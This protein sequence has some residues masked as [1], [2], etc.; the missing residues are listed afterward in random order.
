MDTTSH[1]VLLHIM[2]SQTVGCEEAAKWVRF[3]A[4]LDVAQIGVAGAL[5]DIAYFALSVLLR[6]FLP[7]RYSWTRLDLPLVVRALAGIFL[8]KLYLG[9]PPPLVANIR[10]CVCARPLTST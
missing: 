6:S 9:S 3:S 7:F 2:I 4:V 8:L 5:D 10:A 1:S